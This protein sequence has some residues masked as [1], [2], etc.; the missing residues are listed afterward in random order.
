MLGRHISLQDVPK[1]A[2]QGHITQFSGVQ[3]FLPKRLDSSL[4]RFRSLKLLLPE[5]G[6]LSLPGIRGLESICYN[7]V[8]QDLLGGILRLG[9]DQE[10]GILQLDLSILTVVLG[11]LV[12]VEAVEGFLQA[13]LDL[14]GKLAEF[15]DARSGISPLIAH[16]KFADFVR[17][18]NGLA[19]RLGDNVITAMHL[20]QLHQQKQRNA[21]EIHYGASVNRQL[22]DEHRI[23][24][25][26][27]RGNPLHEFLGGFVELPRQRRGNGSC[28]ELHFWSHPEGACAFMVENL[29]L[30]LEDFVV[31][32]D[33]V[34]LIKPGYNRK[35]LLAS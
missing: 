5:D 3:E 28:V 2:E 23:N 18:E 8:E 26:D 20:G 25:P 15:L 9:V 35:D 16:Q 29:I 19:D 1:V 13:V 32:H 31:L 22:R 11:K 14:T 10:E 21:S 17:A 6:K 4:L 34:V 12:F 27:E 24:L 33:I 7:L 30:F